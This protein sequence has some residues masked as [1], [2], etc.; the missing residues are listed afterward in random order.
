VWLSG[1]VS[2]LGWVMEKAAGVETHLGRF[3]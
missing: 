3:F 2:G 1:G